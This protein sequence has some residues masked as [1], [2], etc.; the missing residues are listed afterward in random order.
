MNNLKALKDLTSEELKKVWN[1]SSNSKLQEI[2][3][4]DF[5]NNTIDFLIN[6]I[7][8][9]LKS[10]L[11][12][13]SIGYYNY[14]YCKVDNLDYE[15]IQTILE[16]NNDIPFLNDEQ[17]KEIESL[18][19]L[20]D[21]SNNLEYEAAEYE[22]AQDNLDKAENRLNEILK[23]ALDNYIEY[24]EDD[25]EDYFISFWFEGRQDDLYINSDYRVFEKQPEY[26][27][28]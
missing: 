14:N 25:L 18:K 6:E 22:P 21:I 15:T 27:Q 16:T 20:I 24:K 8:Q 17:L 28:L 7:F 10:I 3:R 23:N 2:I 9:G 26:V 19:A 4:N 13:W 11:K 5:E 12:D 1:N